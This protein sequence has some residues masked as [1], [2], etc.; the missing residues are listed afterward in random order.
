MTVQ[1]QPLTIG[2]A[3]DIYA[4]SHTLMITGIQDYVR[5]NDCNW[6]LQI[7]DVRQFENATRLPAA[8]AGIITP[9]HDAIFFKQKNLPVVFIQGDSSSVPSAHNAIE[10]SHR[11]LISMAVD[12]LVSKGFKSI[13]FASFKHISTLR[14]V[15]Y[16]EEVFKQSCARHNIRASIYSPESKFEKT[17]ASMIRHMAGWLQ[18]AG[19]PF[20]VIA[21]NDARA[22]DIQQ[23]CEENRIRIPEDIALMG[24]DNNPTICPFMN[25]P[26]TSISLNYRAIG[27]QAAALL[28]ARLSGSSP[29]PETIPFEKFTLIERNSTDI[30]VPQ[31]QLVKEALQFIREHCHQ[32]IQTDE[33]CAAVNASHTTLNRRFKAAVNSSLH[34]SLQRERL[35][36][37][38][39]LLADPALSLKEIACSCGFQTPQYFSTVFRKH[40]NTTPGQ[41]RKI[42]KNPTDPLNPP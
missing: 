22:M 35:R 12:Y 13:G 33:I 14:W 1:P 41:Y 36:R 16:R 34:D 25:P 26:L 42:R 28:Q 19:R 30:S 9:S 10:I 31:D 7:V 29:G 5:E 24:I 15:E 17:R 2:V 37:A 21:L 32:P 20:S 23:C 40:E 39:K 8:F 4:S 11:A 38:K 18:S 27:Y 6:R 3:L